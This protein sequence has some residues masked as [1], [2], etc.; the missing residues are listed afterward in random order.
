MTFDQGNVSYIMNT[1]VCIA[2]L[3]APMLQKCEAPSDLQNN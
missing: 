3:S 1:V 2:H